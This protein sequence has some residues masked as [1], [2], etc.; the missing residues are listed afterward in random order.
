MTLQTDN[1]QLHKNIF[2]DISKSK[3]NQPI[4]Q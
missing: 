1:K 2:P 3:A 4:S